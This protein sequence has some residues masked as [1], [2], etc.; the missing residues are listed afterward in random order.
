MPGRF[1]WHAGMEKFTIILAQKFV[2]GPG[3]CYT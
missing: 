1:D 3:F 2:Y